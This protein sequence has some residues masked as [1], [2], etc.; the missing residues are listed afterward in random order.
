MPA[1]HRCAKSKVLYDQLLDFFQKDPSLKPHDI[2]VMTPDIEKYAPFIHAVFAFPEESGRYIPFSVTDRTPRNES[3]VISTFLSLLALP[4]AACTAT[5]IFSLL[6]CPPL[7]SR[8]KFTD[9]DMGLIR[10]WIVEA[11]IRWGIGRRAPGGIRPAGIG[12]HHMARGVSTAAS[13]LR[14]DRREPSDV[15]GDH[16][17][18]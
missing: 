3:P 6:D 9:D 16:A 1:T 17:L 7:R 10:R 14:D 5:E 4:A 8:F 15:R 18:R 11:G 13:R 12:S 2:I